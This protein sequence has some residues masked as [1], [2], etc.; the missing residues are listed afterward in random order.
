[1]PEQDA[2]HRCNA[3]PLP[4]H[5]QIKPKTS[6]PAAP[7]VYGDE[8][9]CNDEHALCT[10]SPD[11]A[12]RSSSSTK[13]SAWSQNH[14]THDIDLLWVARGSTE[15]GAK[16][17]AEAAAAATR[18]ALSIFALHGSERWRERFNMTGN[19]SSHSIS[20][21]MLPKCF[22]TQKM[23]VLKNLTYLI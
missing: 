17:E 8:H 10:L 14:T 19:N 16:A 22:R 13:Y 5:I 15:A 20:G 18:A 4:L 1:V 23:V 21:F 7:C 11:I 2:L 9:I 6:N 3:T 12:L